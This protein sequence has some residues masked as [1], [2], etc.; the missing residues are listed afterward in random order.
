MGGWYRWCPRWLRHWQGW[1]NE[2]YR[3]ARTSSSSQESSGCI[4]MVQRRVADLSP[5]ALAPDYGRSAFTTCATPSEPSLSE[6]LSPSK[7]FRLGLATRRYARRCG[8]RTTGS[9]MTPPS[10]SPE[11]LSRCLAR[12]PRL[13]RSRLYDGGRSSPGGVDRSCAGEGRGSGTAAC[14]RRGGCPHGPSPSQ[15]QH[16]RGPLARYFRTYCNRVRLPVKR[17]HDSTCRHGV[18]TKLGSDPMK[19]DGHYDEKADIAWL[20]FED[21]DPASLVADE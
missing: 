3:P 1:R 21:Y 20:R 14:G 6:A 5:P 15:A 16:G 13:R 8:T 2:H 9:N 19:I 18:A 17:R 10:G 4:S 12:Y 11:H 7:N